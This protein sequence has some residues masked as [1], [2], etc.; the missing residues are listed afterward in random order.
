MGNFLGLQFKSDIKTEIKK[1]EKDK[2]I[3][4]EH[5]NNLNDEMLKLDEEMS[6]LTEK[7]EKLDQK[8]L[9]H[10]KE[11]NKIDDMIYKF[12]NESKDFNEINPKLRDIFDILYDTYVTIAD[13]YKRIPGTV[14]VYKMMFGT[15]N[16]DITTS[17][18]GS[19]FKQ[20]NEIQRGSGPEVYFEDL[21]Y[22]DD[23]KGFDT[24]LVDLL[25]KKYKLI[26]I[27]I[28]ELYKEARQKINDISEHKISQ[29][30]LSAELLFP[31]SEHYKY[32]NKS[33]ISKATKEFIEVG[34]KNHIFNV[35]YN[36]GIKYI[37]LGN[38]EN[39]TPKFDILK[40]K[41]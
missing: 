35:T 15:A 33:F 3:K 10:E 16:E 19:I 5:I 12:K 17:T 24:D 14:F 22:E 32:V 23:G 7:M 4:I 34:V 6:K 41:I 1:L 2:K 26:S 9:K 29:K 38:N 18:W 27:Q 28:N 11:V 30:V 31:D 36:K 39:F 20:M 37:S 21:K 40:L 25:K 8:I 13:E